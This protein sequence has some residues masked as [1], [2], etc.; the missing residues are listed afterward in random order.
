MQASSPFKGMIKS[1]TITGGCAGWADGAFVFVGA[2]V[3][4]YMEWWLVEACLH[5]K[6]YFF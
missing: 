5:Q 4:K 6:G 2:A 3:T 1:I